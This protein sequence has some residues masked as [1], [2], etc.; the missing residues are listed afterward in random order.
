MIIRAYT[1]WFGVIV[2]L[3]IFLITR[4]IYFKFGLKVWSEV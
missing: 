1:L 2:G 3:I 4:Q